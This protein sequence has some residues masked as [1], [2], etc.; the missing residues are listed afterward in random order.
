MLNQ[1]DIFINNK[2]LIKYLHKKANFDVAHMKMHIVTDKS[3]LKQ[4]TI[5]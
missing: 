4:N 2:I 5:K 3:L 1:S